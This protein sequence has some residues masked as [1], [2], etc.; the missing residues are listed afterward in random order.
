MMRKLFENT[1][2]IA[3]GSDMCLRHLAN[4]SLQL[5]AFKGEGLT[6]D[7]CWIKKCHFP[8]CLPFQP[9]HDSDIAVICT[10]NP[11]D[12][13]PSF[14]YIMWTQTHNIKFKED[15]TKEPIWAYWKDFQARCA[16]MWNQWHAYWIACAEE[17][18]IP[19]YFFRFEDV[20]ADKKNEMEKLMKFI[21]GV[22][23]GIEG[24]VL[25]ER[26]NEVFG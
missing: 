21:A 6:D 8:L 14:F 24:T 11:F 17:G 23:G 16:Q 10:R 7:R 19:V 18:N 25:E 13:S 9:Q 4:L 15:L 1:T 3:T 20:L 22:D 5:A 26:V 12:V 2:G